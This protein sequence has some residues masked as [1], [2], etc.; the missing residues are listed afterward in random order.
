M[1][2]DPLKVSNWRNKLPPL[3]AYGVLVPMHYLLSLIQMLNQGAQLLS[4]YESVEKMLQDTFA[5]QE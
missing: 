5:K 4:K 2:F 3:R 1:D